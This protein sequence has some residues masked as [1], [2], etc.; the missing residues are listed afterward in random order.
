MICRNKL[1]NNMFF[2][3]LIFI[4]S[5]SKKDPSKVTITWAVGKDATGAQNKLVDAFLAQ[6]RNINVRVIEMPGSASSQRDSYVTYLAAKDPFIDVYSIDIIWPAEFAASG[7][8][9]ELDKLFSAKEQDK[10]LPGPIEGC[11][12]KGKIYAVPWFTDAGM[13]YYRKDLLEKAKL[14]PPETW[15]ELIKQAGMCQRKYKING[16]VFQAQQYEGLVCNFLE[17]LWSYGGEVLDSNNKP[18]LNTPPAKQALKTLYDIIHTYKITPE[19]VLTYQEEESRQVFTSGQAAFLRNWPYA[20]ALGQDETVSKVTG[21]IGIAPLPGKTK[22]QGASCLG[23]WNLAISRFSKHPKEAWKFVEFMTSPEV[24]MIYA[25]K[26]GRLPTRKSIYQDKDILDFAP[27]YRDFYKV[28][29]NA[30]PR[31]RTP[32][33]SQISDIL[34]IELHKALTNQQ[35]IDDALENSNRKINTLLKISQQSFEK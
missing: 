16:F 10:F 17:Y 14:A 5:C 12:Y 32:L 27:H 6:N 26:G 15:T 23:G 9:L 24:Q 1:L 34:Q 3:L 25:V 29:V 20:W 8:I 7:W 19:G 31:P 2:I 18:Q 28:F 4:V 21:L 22:G 13:L 11:K 33:Y 30:R 35:S